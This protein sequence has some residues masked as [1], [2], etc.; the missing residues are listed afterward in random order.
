MIIPKLL[1][2][3]IDSEIM[4]NLIMT[5]TYLSFE[6]AKQVKST[7]SGA[8]RSIQEANFAIVSKRIAKSR[9]MTLHDFGMR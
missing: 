4:L 5:I 6:K 1:Q 8:H 3:I 2:H 7:S 9:Q